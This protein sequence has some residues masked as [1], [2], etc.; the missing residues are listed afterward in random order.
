[1][2]ALL[3]LT[4]VA[5]F[6]AG[7]ELLQPGDYSAKLAR[8][9]AELPDA[10]PEELNNRAWF[11]ATDPE[12]SEE[13]LSAALMMAERA[14]DETQREDATILDTLAEVHFVMGR[15]SE[16]LATIEEAIAQNPDER[17]YREQRRRFLGE[18]ADRP[19]APGLPDPDA[20]GGTEAETERGPE[21][22]PG[23]SV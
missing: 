12:V 21:T 13:M 18:R 14:V 23:L 7:G 16:A 4:T 20:L 3:T 6:T 1:M 17:Y 22:D 5:V 10:S 2:V 11:A 9:I 15:E 8:R 19:P